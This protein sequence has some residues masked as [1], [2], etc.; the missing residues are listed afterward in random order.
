VGFVPPILLSR[1]K[2]SKTGTIYITAVTGTN[3]NEFVC[4]NTLKPQNGM[5]SGVNWLETPTTF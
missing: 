2:I 3:N 1:K 4:N 5:I